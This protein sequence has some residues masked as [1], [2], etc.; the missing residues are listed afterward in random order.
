MKMRYQQGVAGG[1]IA[2]IALVVLGFAMGS[3]AQAPQARPGTLRGQVADASGGSVADATILLT[4]PT[5]ETVARTSDAMGTF[6]V[7][8]LAPGNYRLAVTMGGFAPN[9]QGLTITAGQIQQLTVTLEV[10]SQTEE[11]T[12]EE[13]APTV[14]ASPSNN[15]GAVVM[16]GTDLEAL[17][18]DP[19]QLVADL[20][21][22]AGPSAGPNG[23]QIFIDGFAGG[24]LPPKSSIREVRI[25]SNP[26]SSEFDRM[27][28][29][30]IE[31]LTRPGTDAFHGRFNVSGNS[32]GLNTGSPF[33]DKD[34][35]VPYNSTNYDGNISGSLFPSSSF[36]FSAF[37]R[38]INN[39]SIVNAVIL[40][41]SLDQTPFNTGVETPQTRTN[42]SPR[43]DYQLTR[44]NTLTA[45]YQYS[46][47]A[48]ENVGVGGFSLPEQAYSTFETEH[49]LQ[50]SDTQIL[51]ERAVNE[52][53]FRYQA[54]S[55]EETG[56]SATP[57]VRVTGAF[58]GGGSNRGSVT[59]AKDYELQN[60]TSFIA[61]PHML[62]FGGRLRVNRTVDSS[63]N[64]FNGTYTFASIEA[65]QITQEGLLQQ[66]LTTAQI[67]A[68]CILAGGEDRDCGPN[69][70]TI[71][72]GI[73]DASASLVDTGLYLQDDWKLRPNLTLSAGLRFET[74]N[75]IPDHVDFAP[76]LGVAWAIG[77]GGRPT[78]IRAGLGIFYNRFSENNVLQLRRLDGVTQQQYIVTSPDCYP[79]C[80]VGS[81]AGAQTSPTI[82][83]LDSN[84][85]SPY[86]M[87]GAVSV[88]R[89]LTRIANMSI[90]FVSSRGVH[91]LIT[92]NINAPLPGSITD[93]NPT[94]V[95]PFGNVGNIYQYQAV[96]AFRQNQLINSVNIR[97]GARL[98]LFGNY[99][100]NYAHN[101]TATGGF[102]S[103]PYN[104]GLDAGRAN[105][106]IRHRVN[107]GG[108]ISLPWALRVSPFIS[109]Q[110]SPPFNITVGEDLNGDSQFNDRPAFA[111]S[112]TLP[113]NLVATEYGSF[114]TAPL[115]GATLVPINY[116][117]GTSRVAVNLRMAKTFSFGGGAERPA[118][119]GA[120]GG[121]PGGPGGLGGPGGGGRGGFGG[122]GGRGGFGGRGGGGGGSGRY[123]LT[124]NVDA[125]NIFNKVNLNNPVGNLS[126][127]L[128]GQANSIA[129]GPFSTGAAVRRIDL[130]L[131]FSF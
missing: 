45:R 100:L 25:N 43:F 88:E 108:S 13:V 130:S 131:A 59:E 10:A 79:T 44:D 20:Q 36:S 51:G 18:D 124:F 109:M 113:E 52:T 11:V 46:R 15:A 123:N 115:A 69:Q 116:G 61:G 27:G 89:Q 17:S 87:Q 30:R 63:T 73:P 104:L 91:S 92:N 110:S 37:R 42:I 76:R 81:L 129:G 74:Q 101:Y 40:D 41:P 105:N 8:D 122:G 38:N 99:V 26:F 50:V 22:L 72:A 28:F 67:R 120:P 34:N 86:I 65:Y 54:A 16:S 47:E 32:S 107:I 102:P 7:A 33:V 78:V 9:E 3:I 98:S 39:S 19:D 83:Q 94:G 90:N 71:T 119:A 118:A 85:R 29:G 48:A 1:R 68:N 75:H 95:R 53:R 23:G 84:L 80:S 24:Q 106:D 57:T 55:E 35:A 21:A 121:G 128:F 49:S 117:S 12:V 77:Q 2:L 62:R 127:P 111:T 112:Q 82:Y 31:I 103:D 58:T 70:F 126:S 97:A 96:G 125:R 64:N 93:A 4:T 66:G 5:G 56:Q 6:E 14:D 60:F 114:D